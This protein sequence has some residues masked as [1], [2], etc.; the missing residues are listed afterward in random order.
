MRGC[1]VEQG[2]AERC[3]F[4]ADDSVM[5]APNVL[6]ISGS[7]DALQRLQKSACHSMPV[8]HDQRL[9]GLL[10]AENFGEFLM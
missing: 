6:V 5:L 10:I 8:L 1:L 2:S 4:D 9:V 3:Y 7:S